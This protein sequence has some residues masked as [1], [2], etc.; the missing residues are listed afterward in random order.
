MQLKTLLD[1][2]ENYPDNLKAVKMNLVIINMITD[3]INY[4]HVCY[5]G[6]PEVTQ[7]DFQTLVVIFLKE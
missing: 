3:H 6:F 7:K 1:I 5:S 2:H 4:E